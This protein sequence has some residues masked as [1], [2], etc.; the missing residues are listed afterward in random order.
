MFLSRDGKSIFLVVKSNEEILKK[1]A[2]KVKFRKQ[3]ELG[4]CDLFALE[5]VDECYRPLRIKDYFDNSQRGE[6]IGDFEGTRA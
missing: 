6:N 1:Y 3:L 5:P 4:S 2:D